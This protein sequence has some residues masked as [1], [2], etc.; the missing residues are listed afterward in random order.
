MVSQV[1][2]QVELKFQIDKRFDH[3]DQT[4]F[5][6]SPIL[7]FRL[8]NI[9]FY[10]LTNMHLFMDTL[11]GCAGTFS[12]R[13]VFASLAPSCQTVGCLLRTL[14]GKDWQKNDCTKLVFK[15]SQTYIFIREFYLI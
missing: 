9:H 15:N 12:R 7:A 8:A 2:K 10:I 5:Q 3:I 14:S 6:I 1:S 13:N 4:C 11:R